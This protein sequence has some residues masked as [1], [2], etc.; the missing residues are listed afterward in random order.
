MSQKERKSLITIKQVK[1]EET[2][3]L[4]PKK[5]QAQWCPEQAGDLVQGGLMTCNIRLEET[6]CVDQSDGKKNGEGYSR[7]E[8][9]C[10]PRSVI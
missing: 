7:K 8:G 4:G 9:Q 1:C 5:K 10:I 3:T 6:A 2:H